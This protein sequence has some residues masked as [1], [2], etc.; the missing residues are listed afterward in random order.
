MLFKKT[1]H[2]IY[3]STFVE[4]KSSVYFYVQKDKHSD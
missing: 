1:E 2:K 4:D 3:Y